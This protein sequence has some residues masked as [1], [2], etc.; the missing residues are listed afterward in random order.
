[1]ATFSLY[2]LFFG[3]V[4]FGFCVP[5]GEA[6][7]NKTFGDVACASA[8]PSHPRNLDPSTDITLGHQRPPSS[9][10]ISWS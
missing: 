8:A 10:I 2:F 6:A 4:R 7:I 9:I 5:E 3:S 1:M